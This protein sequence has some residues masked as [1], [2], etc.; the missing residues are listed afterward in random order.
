VYT[1][2]RAIHKC[3]LKLYHEKKKPHVNMIRK[4]GCLLWAEA[5]LKWKEEKK[6]KAALWSDESNI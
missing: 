1:G 3:R 4:E 2:Y 6:W 5:H